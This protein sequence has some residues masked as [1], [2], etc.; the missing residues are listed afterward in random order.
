M[1]LLA[2][3]ATALLVTPAEIEVP[4][5]KPKLE[6]AAN[7]RPSAPS[8]PRAAPPPSAS[9]AAAAACDAEADGAVSALAGTTLGDFKLLERL[10]GAPLQD[11]S[12]GF[13]GAN[14]AVY[15]AVC[16][17][18]S[19][20]KTLTASASQFAIKV[21]FRPE[22]AADG[23][24]WENHWVEDEDDE[25]TGGDDEG[26]FLRGGGVN[27]TV[28]AGS[29]GASAVVFA[30]PAERMELALQGPPAAPEAPG[31]L[32]RHPSLLPIYHCF[33]DAVDPARLPDWQ[34][35]AGGQTAS[36]GGGNAGQVPRGAAATLFFVLPL[37]GPNLHHHAT[38]VIRS[39]LAVAAARKQLRGSME[40]LTA[41][42]TQQVQALPV[43][44]T[45]GWVGVAAQLAAGLEHMAA[46][47]LA[48]RDIKLDNILLKDNSA[49]AAGSDVAAEGVPT[50]VLT[51]FGAAL[52]AQ[53]ARLL[54]EEAPPSSSS[55]RSSTSGSASQSSATAGARDR[56]T[57][58]LRVPAAAALVSVVGGAKRRGGNPYNL[59]PEVI[60]PPIDSED[61]TLDYTGADSWGLGTVLHELVAPTV[62]AW[63][64]LR[65]AE[66]PFAYSFDRDR[67]Q[68]L[69]ASFRPTP[70][71]LLEVAGEEEESA[72]AGAAV[73]V[74]RESGFTLGVAVVAAGLVDKCLL[75]PT[76]Q[77]TAG[78][79]S[80]IRLPI[81]EARE[82]FAALLLLL[83]WDMHTHG[84][85]FHTRSSTA[86]AD[87][88][89]GGEENGHGREWPQVELGPPLEAVQEIVA[90]A[91]AE[92]SRPS[93]SSGADGKGTARGQSKSKGKG[94][95]SGK[96]QQT[97]AA[98]GGAADGP[99]WVLREYLEREPAV[100]IHQRLSWLYEV[101]GAGLSVPWPHKTE[102]G[103]W[104][105]LDGP[106]QLAHEKQR[107]DPEPTV[108]G[109]ALG[110]DRPP[111]Y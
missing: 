21:M 108:D 89:E 58:L 77:P 37:T 13:V 107:G 82:G 7:R 103:V 16:I 95:S 3:L 72:K 6:R 81:K 22:A 96:L 57:A 5:S 109:G 66:S 73:A 64:G 85:G 104:P 59:P 105:P 10:G 12:R 76:V 15:R 26:T 34:A 110:G 102:G 39:R 2:L 69:R 31:R 23:D 8:A 78:D 9:A 27:C 83:W 53:E 60:L 92:L 67:Y 65:A 88:A 71:D 50:V 47:G 28:A 62:E 32:G 41:H 44:S 68:F 99:W 101:Y 19:C 43:L 75:V 25:T 93:P 70:P 38:H 86:D 63:P 4:P 97:M 17:A 20:R 35:D 56:D 30:S 24:E 90:A 106:W 91:Q 14:A 36:T 94:K 55:S 54:S 98:Q 33:V 49:P 1:A 42:E 46:A 51:D 61:A 79:K 80:P 52:D 74:P 11:G 18:P 87:D 100:I 48:H 29:E 40:P 111:G 84:S 45:I